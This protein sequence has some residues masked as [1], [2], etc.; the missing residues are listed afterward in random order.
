MGAGAGKI[1]VSCEFVDKATGDVVFVRKVDGKV[2]GAG[3][4]TEGAVKGISKEIA[5]VVEKAW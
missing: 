3:Q 2:I 5:G 1:V 4:S